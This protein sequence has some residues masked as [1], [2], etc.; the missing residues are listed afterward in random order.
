MTRFFIRLLINAVGLYAAVNI[1]PGIQPLAGTD[2]VSYVFL[3]LIFGFLNA[4]LRPLLKLL[5]C[6]L[7]IL[8]LGLFTMLINTLLFWLT[9]VVGQQMQIG[10]TVDGFWPAFFG[11]LVVSIVS[12]ILATLVKDENKDR[13]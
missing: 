13:D 2:W 1:V 4:L 10:F 5:T 12:V 7:I 11:A 8:T 9:G 3:A 6:P